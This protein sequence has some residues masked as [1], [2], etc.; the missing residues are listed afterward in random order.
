M[1]EIFQIIVV[2]GGHAG[3]EAALAAARLGKKTALITMD[4]RAVGRASCNP[5]IG[6]LAKG[7][8]VR[9]I[10]ILGGV[11]GL[12]A[13]E[14]GIQF[15][16]LN[17]SKGR[18]VWSP[19]AQIDKRRY[20][21]YVNRALAAEDNIRIIEGEAVDLTMKCGRCR[22]VIL[23]DGSTLSSQAV[24]LTCGTFLN[25]LIHIGGRK[26]PA[27][28]MG[29]YAAAGLTEALTAL[30]FVSG[31]LKTGTPPR[32]L[33]DSIDWSQSSAFYGDDRPTPFS[34]RTQH[35]DPPN[36]ACHTVQT[37]QTCHD[38]IHVN[39]ERA[40]L[41]SGDINGA[42][43]R[44]CPSI[45][46][47]I[48][49]FAHH[50]SHTLFLEPEWENSEQIYVNGFSTS[51]PEDIQ[52]KALR[53]VPALKNAVFL[54]PGYAIE[55]DFFL[56]SQ[57]KASLETKLVP[58]LFLGG[59]INGT[60]GYEEAAAQGL[61][62]GVNAACYIEECQPL[63]LGRDQA[64]TGVLIDDLITKDTLEPYRM[65]T[66]RA[67]YRLLLRYSNADRRLINISR[68]F[69][70][71]DDPTY[72]YLQ[73]KLASTDQLSQVLSHKIKP[74]EINQRLDEAGESTV[75]EATSGSRLLKRPAITISMLPARIFDDVD[76]GRY[77]AGIK[78]EIYAEAETAIKYAG[79]IQRQKRQVEKLAAQEQVPIAPDFDFSAIK[80]ISNEGRE[81]LI[82][83]RPE[84]LGQAMRISGVTPAD[85]AVLAVVLARPA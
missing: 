53:T 19:R 52:M 24:I 21:H 46:D 36:H 27:G 42:G 22:G 69:N 43:P 68:K 80:S 38:I 76:L 23:A 56:P 74:A 33:R 20:E 18:S 65:F 26:I 59:Q 34:Y 70:L 61:I 84:T 17:R 50:A 8:M 30:G 64:Y 3:I 13:D 31:R 29:E 44:Y 49:R 16:I 47:K 81:K 41:F 9:E 77:T 55:Y 63:V 15:K 57:L 51:L 66:S 12:A 79:Y 25:G 45:E 78:D 62:C 85:I 75:T 58:G 83:V 71:I 10:D 39:K 2:G 4:T 6:G 73:Q 72:D 5:A 40:P 32:I 37:N 48:Y 82:L 14:A 11:M 28:R 60:S 7:Q 1:A 35:F 67:E 54:R